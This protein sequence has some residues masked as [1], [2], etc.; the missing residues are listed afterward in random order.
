MLP[1]NTGGHTAYQD[2]FLSDFLKFYPDPFA[3]PRSTWNFIMQFW[4]LTLPHR[5][6]DAKVLLFLW[7]TI[8]TPIL[9]ASLLP[10]SCV[11][12]WFP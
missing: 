10:T 11:R 4:F 9:H 5:L 3:L 1:V 8:T 12:D 6:H 2:T 7:S